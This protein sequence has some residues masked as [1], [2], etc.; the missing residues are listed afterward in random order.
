MTRIG[1]VVGGQ[2]QQVSSYTNLSGI[3]L[4]CIRQFLT[5][6]DQISHFSF[7]L[8]QVEVKLWDVQI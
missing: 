7:R 2:R 5:H 8:L 1:S 3:G 4:P 6:F